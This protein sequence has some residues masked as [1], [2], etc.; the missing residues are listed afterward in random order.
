MGE[1]TGGQGRGK[2]HVLIEETICLVSWKLFD[3]RW[4][5]GGC[6]EH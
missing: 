3:K 6:R 1:K 2:L 4:E 5:N